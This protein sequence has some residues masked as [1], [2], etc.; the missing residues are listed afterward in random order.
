MVAARVIAAAI[1]IQPEGVLTL[2]TPKLMR[3]EQ[4]GDGF[5]QSGR[6]SGSVPTPWPHTAAR[7]SPKC[8]VIPSFAVWCVP[9]AQ[10]T[11]AG[12]WRVRDPFLR[13]KPPLTMEATGFRSTGSLCP[14]CIRSPPL[15]EM[16]SGR[17]CFT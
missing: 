1:F 5:L 12:T 16:P 6:L 14:M 11:E 7:S 2:A 9:G 3:I 15:L 10:S 17:L 8:I 4:C 13:L